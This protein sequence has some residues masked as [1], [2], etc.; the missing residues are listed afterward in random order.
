MANPAPD[1]APN[2][3]L[4][5]LLSDTLRRVEGRFALASGMRGR[6]NTTIP[7]APATDSIDATALAWLRGGSADSEALA[8][9]RIAD[10]LHRINRLVDDLA[11]RPARPV[12]TANEDLLDHLRRMSDLT[13]ALLTA[14]ANS[15]RDCDATQAERVLADEDALDEWYD[16]LLAEMLDDLHETGDAST[17]LA[18]VLSIA[19]ILERIGDHAH[20]IAQC[21]RIIASQ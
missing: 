7:P 6:T 20:H 4:A 18:P 2:Q 17:A 19:R 9:L 3:S 11:Q 10:D 13:S 5:R 14:S 16:M 21:T 8:V 1:A 15:L 12:A